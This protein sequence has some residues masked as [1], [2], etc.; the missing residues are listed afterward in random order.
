[1]QPVLV[2]MFD[3]L[4]KQKPVDTK[5]SD[6]AL[7][8]MTKL[9][10]QLQARIDE[11]RDLHVKADQ[12]KQQ[13]L[14]NALKAK[15]DLDDQVEDL[16]MKLEQEEDAKLAADQSLRQAKH[17]VGRL[18][19]RLDEQTTSLENAEVSR[20]ELQTRAE[21]AE[22]QHSMVASQLQVVQ[23]ELQNAKNEIAN[24]PRTIDRNA[25]RSGRSDLL[26]N[27]ERQS[28]ERQKAAFNLEKQ[29]FQQQQQTQA[30]N[31]QRLQQEKLAA[32]AKVE[33]LGRIISGLRADVLALQQGLQELETWSDNA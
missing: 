31:L 16:M 5:A 15:S 2:R 32:D 22:S 18:Q 28:L 27:L 6:Q 10:E 4:G 33:E 11:M 26:D 23:T 14:D 17:N 19:Q 13:L 24:A 9:N 8:A 20:L 30:E 3:A 1:M 12:L 21:H 29:T 7:N 25:V